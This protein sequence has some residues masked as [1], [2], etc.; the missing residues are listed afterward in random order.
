ML[1]CLDPYLDAKFPAVYVV[2]DRWAE[3]QLSATLSFQ[4]S[5]P[6][7]R[8]LNNWTEDSVSYAYVDGKLAIR[9]SPNARSQGADIQ[10]DKIYGYVIH[11]NCWA[12]LELAASSTGCALDIQALH[13][14][15]ASQPYQF[16]LN[17]GHDYG[18]AIPYFRPVAELYHGE[19]AV[20]DRDAALW[21]IG[22]CDPLDGDEVDKLVQRS[23]AVPQSEYFCSRGIARNDNR[24]HDIFSVLPI[25]IRS[26]IMHEA[27]MS[28]R[29]VANLR[30]AS[31]G[32]AS[33]TL[34]ETFLESRF[35][36]TGEFGHYFL[37]ASRLRKQGGSLQGLFHHARRFEALGNGAERYLMHQ[38]RETL[39]QVGVSRNRKRIWNMALGL[40]DLVR[41]RSN[42]SNCHGTAQH[43]FYEHHAP[44]DNAHWASVAGEISTKAQFSQGC[45]ALYHRTVT[46]PINLVTMSVS[47]VRQFGKSYISGLHFHDDAGETTSLGYMPVFPKRN[48]AVIWKK[49]ERLGK[50]T[51]LEA[52]ID[53][54]GIR[55]I[56][57]LNESGERSD[58]IGEWQDLPKSLIQIPASKRVEGIQEMKAGFDVSST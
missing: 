24:G 13:D 51:G 45:R 41:I 12:L 33:V 27:S 18:G 26:Y 8:S 39:Q 47:Q 32:C 52:A 17:W 23:S 42:S 14:I 34:T 19:E 38:I 31:V 1:N 55:G 46:L 58:W 22:L 37:E 29:D 48:S 30:R 50:I 49:S 11:E 10:R 40:L 54:R 36:P 3:A 28:Y 16:P 7:S 6:R 53:T 9:P 44:A 20:F 5:V 35:Y 25:E 56:L 57:M 43:T 2:G 4:G 15:C 21:T